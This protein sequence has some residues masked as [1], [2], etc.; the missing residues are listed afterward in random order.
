MYSEALS[1][2]HL[3]HSHLPWLLQM[4]WEGR[5]DGQH[6]RTIVDTQRHWESARCQL[7]VALSFGHR[8][9]LQQPCPVR[10]SLVQAGQ[11]LPLDCRCRC[12]CSWDTR[13]PAL[14]SRSRTHT[15]PWSSDRDL[16][17]KRR[18]YPGSSAVPPPPA[19]SAA[20]LLFL[21]VQRG[22]KQTPQHPPCTF[23]S[24]ESPQPTASHSS[25]HASATSPGTPSLCHQDRAGHS[26]S[27]NGGMLGAAGPF[28]PLQR[29]PEVRGHCRT[30]Y[31]QNAPS[32]RCVRSSE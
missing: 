7:P 11:D 21:G 3:P 10:S 14:P 30:S 1:Q 16:R 15:R 26:T 4:P 12:R 2:M 17:D 20:L 23:A 19:L 24:T 32:K 27:H 9:D 8:V 22:C 28:S 25:P 31:W 29:K 5:G 13:S 6:P 18:N